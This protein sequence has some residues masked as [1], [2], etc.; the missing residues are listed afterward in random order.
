MNFIEIK[1]LFVSY[2]YLADEVSMQRYIE[3][4]LYP[5]KRTCFKDLNV[6]KECSLLNH[7]ENFSL[8]LNFLGIYLL[9]IP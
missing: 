3:N 7:M 5:M 4:L 8:I 1:C 2:L 9:G 6:V